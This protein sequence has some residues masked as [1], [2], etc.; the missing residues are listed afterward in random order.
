VVCTKGELADFLKHAV[1]VEEKIDG[2]N[3]GV[4]MSDQFEL[5][6]QNRAHFVNSGSAA[7]WSG[8]D[9]WSAQ[10]SADLY[11]LL[12]PF[13]RADGTPVRRILF[14]EWM[15][16]RHSV[17]YDKLPGYF[18]AFDIAEVDNEGN[19]ELLSVARRNELLAETAIPVI[20]AVGEGVF[21]LD[22]L[23]ALLKNT[24]SHYGDELIEGVYL[25]A[26]DG[27]RNVSR[28]KIVR[29]DFIQNIVTHWSKKELVKNKIQW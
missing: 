8:L 16:A 19:G 12:A 29:A 7:Q 28:G 4:S 18:I 3:L 20:A 27:D 24:T 6:F 14:G 10:F 17:A 1:T 13:Q 5:R 11:T 23:L 26:D 9:A 22:Q 15:M 2:A 25:K 21:T